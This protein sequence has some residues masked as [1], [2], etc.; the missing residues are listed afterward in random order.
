MEPGETN[1]SE[2]NEEK[3]KNKNSLPTCGVSVKAYVDP[4]DADVE[5]ETLEVLL[6]PKKWPFRWRSYPVSSV[7][8]G[9]VI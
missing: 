9:K 8:R 4:S 5:A 7:T 3:E 6:Q 1:G 2:A